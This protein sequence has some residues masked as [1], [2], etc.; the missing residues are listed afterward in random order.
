MDGVFVPL[1]DAWKQDKSVGAL[2]CRYGECKL[3]IV[4]EARTDKSGQD[5][6][7]KMRAYTATLEKVE[8][9]GP[10]LGTLAHQ[11]GHHQ[12]KEVIVLA[13]GAPWIWQ[14]AAK[15]F[16]GAT[17]IVDF[18]HVSQHLAAVAEARFGSGSEE[19]K[20][21]L[22]ARQAEL[23]N[24]ELAL[25]LADLQSWRPSAKAKKEL[26]R[27]TYCYLY[28]NAERLRY[29]TFREKGYYIGSGVVEA[30]CK[31]VATQR[32]KQSGM[33]WRQ[34]TAEAVLALRAAQ[35]STYPPDLRP[36]C[37]MPA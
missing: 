30:G 10:L 8:T 32:M 14:I 17:Q 26:R 2:H 23:L 35:L 28:A 37:A 15:Q 36:Y 34:E 18:F 27:T 5:A 11:L 6:Q 21:W 33:H 31:Q 1:R 16:T 19:A 24:E 9:F 4:Y 29:K 20:T 12:A 22:R 3:G 7:V 25:V 13:D